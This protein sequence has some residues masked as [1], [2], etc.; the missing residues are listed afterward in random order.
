MVLNDVYLV[1]T[2]CELNINQP[3]QGSLKGN[4]LIKEKKKKLRKWA[5]KLFHIKNQLQR[6]QEENYGTA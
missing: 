4:H 3:Q 1:L 5:G 6:R 2:K